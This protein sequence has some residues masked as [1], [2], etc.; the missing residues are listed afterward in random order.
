MFGNAQI[1]GKG[2]VGFPTYTG[3]WFS[4]GI[5]KGP[6][7]PSEDD[8]AGPDPSDKYQAFLA[9][10]GYLSDWTSSDISSFYTLGSYSLIDIDQNGTDELIIVSNSDIGFLAFLVYT[11][12]EK[13]GEIV[14]LPAARSDVENNILSCYGDPR[15][16]PKYKALVFSETKPTAMY[17]GVEY[18]VVAG[19]CLYSIGTVGADSFI[20]EGKMTYYSTLSGNFEEISES[21]RDGYISELTWLDYHPLP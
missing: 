15:Y 6:V 18:F 1:R 19:D 2:I 12:D 16:S 13:S 14:R 4:D 20:S 9:N 21:D 8:P 3:T 5:V 17:G 10:R 11:I 7:T